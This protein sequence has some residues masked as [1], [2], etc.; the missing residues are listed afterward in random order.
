MTNI[1]FGLPEASEVALYIYDVA[2]REVKTLVNESQS[3]GWYTVQWNGT[4]NNGSLVGTGMYFARI[5]AGDY[6]KVIKMVYLR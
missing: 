5:Q 3:A 4:T 2:G 1:R 6:S